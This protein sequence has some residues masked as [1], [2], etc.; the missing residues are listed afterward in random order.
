MPN[1]TNLGI[2]AEKLKEF[3]V[4]MEIKCKGLP[5]NGFVKQ[6]LD[7][8][9]PPQPEEVWNPKKGEEAFVIS[10]E[11]RVYEVT[12]MHDFSEFTPFDRSF[13]FPTRE[14][15]EQT[16]AAWLEFRGIKM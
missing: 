5:E 1:Q 2:N 14:A 10:T 4:T 16:K 13:Y 6:M 15:A 9:F 8:A 12:L 3:L 11:G 7:E